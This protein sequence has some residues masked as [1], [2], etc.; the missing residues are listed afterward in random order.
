MSEHAADDVTDEQR[1]VFVEGPGGFDGLGEGELLDLDRRGNGGKAE[2]VG[3]GA[4]AGVQ[5][6]RRDG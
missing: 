1:L 5:E 2:T 3:L 4:V 6:C